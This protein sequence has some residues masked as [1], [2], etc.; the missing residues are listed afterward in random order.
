MYIIKNI[1]VLVA[2]GI[3]CSTTAE[4]VVV[5]RESAET[6]NSEIVLRD[7]ADIS[8]EYASLLDTLV[9]GHATAPG[10]NRFILRD[11]IFLFTQLPSEVKNSITLS[12][13][14]RCSVKSI[15]QDITIGDIIGDVR[16]LLADELIWDRENWGIDLG[17][18]DSVVATIWSGE[19]KVSLGRV[20]SNVL[21]GNVVIPVVI[22]QIDQSRNRVNLSGR[23]EVIAEVPVATRQIGSGETVQRSDYTTETKNI[24]DLPFDPAQFQAGVSYSIR[25]GIVR[26][27]SVIT[28]NRVRENQ[29]IERGNVITIISTVGSASVQVR[30]MARQSGSVGDLISVENSISRKMIQGTVIRPGVVQVHKGGNV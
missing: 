29:T 27:G 7:I 14:I 19:Y 1:L 9:V 2:M 11:E 17:S 25:S 13:A 12:G 28:V 22:T 3:L 8:G 5:V 10:Y 26:A 30:G 18:I 23:I 20:R 15:G 24:T 6:S 4:T 16:E 21:K